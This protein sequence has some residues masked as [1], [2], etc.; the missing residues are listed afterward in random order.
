[1]ENH[2]KGNLSDSKNK[3]TKIIK[4]ETATGTKINMI[5]PIY[6]KK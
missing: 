5:F 3:E 1:M 4:T 6:L 2:G